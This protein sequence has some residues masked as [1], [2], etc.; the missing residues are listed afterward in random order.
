M[1]HSVTGSKEKA[2]T[3][4]KDDMWVSC[5][6]V[7]VYTFVLYV[8]NFENMCIKKCVTVSTKACAG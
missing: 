7:C 5:M 4:Q 3:S 1:V 8:L 6:G 2:C